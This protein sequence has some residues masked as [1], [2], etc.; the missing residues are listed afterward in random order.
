MKILA[1]KISIFFLLVTFLVVVTNCQSQVS[2]H[3]TLHVEVTSTPPSVTETPV[4]RST[5]PLEVTSTPSP[6]TETPVPTPSSTS[7]VRLIEIS[8]PYYSFPY[9]QVDGFGE[10]GSGKLSGIVF[11][12]QRHTLFAVNDE[13]RI[14]EIA[15][16]GTFIRQKRIRKE[17]DFEGIT[18]NP[19]T[20]MLYVAIEGEEAILE[21]DP[22]TLEAGRDILIDRT[23]EGNVLL[24]PEGNGIEGIT[25]VPAS[26]NATDGTFYLVNQSNRLAGTDPSIVLEVEV[27]N[28]ADEPK[29]RI[30]RY[31]S[32]GV[33]DLSGIH[34]VPS[35]RRLLITSDDNNSLLVVDLS[36]QILETYSLP[37]EKQEG[38]TIDADGFLYI[39][40]DTKKELL[41]FKPIQAIDAR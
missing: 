11:H 10:A 36:G 20:G 34:Y 3:A 25:F 32:V 35:T 1:S 7:E 37:G 30:I 41:K 28:G 17:A 6:I 5:L 27:S 21:I 13:G 19:V 2:P 12:P 9:E 39:A 14:I 31:F 40:Q 8:N 24:A 38:V 26:A 18:N 4:P 15:T 23:F 16:D 22:E 33:T 29:A